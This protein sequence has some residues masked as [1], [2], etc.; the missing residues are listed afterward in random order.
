VEGELGAGVMGREWEGPLGG[1]ANTP[2]DT[3]ALALNVLMAAGFSKSYDYEGGA[4]ATKEGDT[5]GFYGDALRIVLGN[6]YR[7]IMT[8]ML[9]GLPS[10]AIPKKI[11]EMKTAL[12]EVEDYISAMMERIG[13][14]WTKKGSRETIS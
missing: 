4:Q 1:V 8:S 12:K 14:D 3:I 10:W 2:N 13:P 7:A 5:M 9:M 6:L 11:T